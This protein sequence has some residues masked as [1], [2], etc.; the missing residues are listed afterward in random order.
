MG[1]EE[2]WV[3]GWKVQW[4]ENIFSFSG[5][6]HLYVHSSTGRWWKWLKKAA[7]NKWKNQPKGKE[8]STEILRR[9]LKI[10]VH[11]RWWK[12]D[13]GW[14][15]GRM[16]GSWSQS[17][18]F[19][20][21][22]NIAAAEAARTRFASAQI[23]LCKNFIFQLHN[24]VSFIFIFLCSITCH[25]HARFVDYPMWKSRYCILRFSSLTWLWMLMGKKKSV[26]LSR[27]WEKSASPLVFHNFTWE[28]PNKRWS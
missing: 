15:E 10:I 8:E 17:T 19:P 27:R 16:D 26:V 21:L 13:V 25:I 2:S 1:G 22:S 6:H 4:W 14:M 5:T 9:N 7:T 24:I 3:R 11:T 18:L 28:Q 20:S 23:S 12:D